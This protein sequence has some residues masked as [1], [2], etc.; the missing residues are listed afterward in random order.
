ML[1]R[2]IFAITALGLASLGAASPAE[3][4]E[5]VEEN[6]RPCGLK[7]APC[8]DTDFCRPVNPRCTDLNRCRGVCT[9]KPKRPYPPQ[10]DYKSC[11]GFRATPVT[12][13]AGSTCRD[14]PRKGGC[15]MACDAP[16]ICIPDNAPKC[17]GFAGFQCPQ[18]LTCYDLPGDGCDPKNGGADCIGVCLRS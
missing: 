15:G 17:A 13:D 11:G 5:A 14:D 2:A 18:G 6:G 1:A 10:G 12:C 7:I 9:R 16:G 4:V 3:Q 8:P